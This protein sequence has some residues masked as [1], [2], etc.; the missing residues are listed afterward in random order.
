MLKSPATYDEQISKLKEHGCLISNEKR[1]REI[2]SGISYFRISA[3]FLPFRKSNK[4]YVSGTTFERVYRLYEFDREM[5]RLLFSAVE[6]I[7]VALRAKLS[8]YYAHKYGAVGYMDES[9]FNPKHNHRRFISMIDQSKK[10]NSRLLFVKHYQTKYMGEFPLWVIMEL[11]TMGM[12]S[13]FYSDMLTK[14]KKLFTSAVYGENYKDIESWLRCC[15]DL[16]NICAHYGRLYYR[17]FSAIPAGMKEVDENA[18]RRLFAAILVV[19]KLYPDKAKW[20]SEIFIQLHAI[21]DEYRDAISL[22]HVG[23]P[24][25]WEEILA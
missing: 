11:F 3:Y 23:F 7:E 1:V 22:K 10:E 15:T 25:N 20:S 9:N 14:D 6:T 17:I 21:M 24:E 8:Y 5:R 4:S 18:E 19:K 16:R 13:S 12:L 2:L